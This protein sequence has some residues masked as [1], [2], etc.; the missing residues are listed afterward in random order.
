[1]GWFS[2]AT[3]EEGNTYSCMICH[4]RLSP[5]EARML[6][7]VDNSLAVVAASEYPHHDIPER[8]YRVKGMVCGSDDCETKALQAGR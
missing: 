7:S 3:P 1:M 4:A 6:V 8:G 2:K 5:A